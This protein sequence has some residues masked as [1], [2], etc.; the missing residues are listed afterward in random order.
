[1]TAP[2]QASGP[3]GPA[4]LARQTGWSGEDW[5]AAY[6]VVPTMFWPMAWR[7][8][9]ELAGVTGADPGRIARK[10]FDPETGI[11]PGAPR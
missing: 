8:I 4:E 10:L 9:A 11:V 1:M 5:Q 7:P 2:N 3:P 6:A